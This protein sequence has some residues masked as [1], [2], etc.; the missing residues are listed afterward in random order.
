MYAEHLTRTRDR[1]HGELLTPLAWLARRVAEGQHRGRIGPRVV[2]P[3]YALL[4]GVC[5]GSVS[6]AFDEARPPM[7]AMT[8]KASFCVGF[9]M[10]VAYRTRDVPGWSDWAVN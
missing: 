3:Y 8:A 7:P 6:A 1:L 2:E 4:E 5:L 10:R 9:T